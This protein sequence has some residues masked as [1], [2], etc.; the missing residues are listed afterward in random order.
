[1][2]SQNSRERKTRDEYTLQGNYGYG[3][4]DL[5]SEDTLFDI[6]ARRKEYRDNEPGTPVRIIKRRIR[7]SQRDVARQPSRRRTF[8]VCPIGT[9]TQTVILSKDLF[10]KREA[11][12]WIR[13]HDFRISKIDETTNSWRFR[14]QPPGWFEKGSFRTIRLRPG[15]TAVIGCP[16]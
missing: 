9:Q 14:Q 3:W 10:N 13:E 15:V 7:L 5:T 2:P 8:R 16:R 12:N 4:E 1:M 6:R 11:G